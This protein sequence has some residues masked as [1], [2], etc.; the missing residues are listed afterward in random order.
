MVNVSV[1]VKLTVP[2]PFIYRS[3]DLSIY[4]SVCLSIYLYIYIYVC[5]DESIWR[6][7]FLNHWFPLATLKCFTV[8]AY[9]Q[10]VSMWQ[11]GHLP[12][13]FDIFMLKIVTFAKTWNKVISG[14]FPLWII[15]GFYGWSSTHHV[16]WWS[17][18]MFWWFSPLLVAKYLC[19]W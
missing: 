4:L 19:F 7:V 9:G 3:I 16:P 14:S 1:L 15:N 11:L 8:R 6:H 17:C 10:R 5:P 13:G 12:R 18:S 2:Y